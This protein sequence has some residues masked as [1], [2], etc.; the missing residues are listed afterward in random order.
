MS[1]N[2]LPE[3]D[4]AGFLDEQRFAAPEPKPEKYLAL[5]LPKRLV[6]SLQTLGQLPEAT[7]SS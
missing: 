6:E 4:L 7:L 2:L 5:H 3:L 1:V